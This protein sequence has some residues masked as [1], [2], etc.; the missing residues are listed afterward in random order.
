M[1]GLTRLDP[2]YM[3]D[4]FLMAAFISFLHFLGA[5]ALVAAL[6]VEL[7][8]IREELTVRN[9]TKLVVADAV[10]G[11]SAGLVLVAGLLRVFFFEKGSAYY[12]ANIP[13]LLKMALFFA[14]A[15]ASIY[16]TFEFLK[17][18]KPLKQ[19]QIP[20]LRD[21]K[22]RVIRR[23]IHWELAA[24]LLLILCAALMARGIGYRA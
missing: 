11:L 23:L 22:R 6:V 10:Y 12:F 4:E 16:P 14:I 15:A 3:F 1:V 13:F 5:F 20:L 24:V 2:R 8:T 21:D 17:W 9:A 18:Y 19:G 7:V